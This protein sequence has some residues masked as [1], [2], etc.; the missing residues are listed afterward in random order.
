MILETE[1]NDFI[2]TYTNWLSE[3]INFHILKSGIAEITV[4]F[5]DRNNDFIT[6]YLLKQDNGQY[7]LSDGGVT[8]SELE[9]IGM[10]F[11]KHRSKILTEILNGYGVSI[12]DHKELYIKTNKQRL[13]QNKNMLLQAIH[14]VNDMVMLNKQTVLSLFSED[15]YTF[16]V[17]ND[18]PVVRDAK[19]SGKSG[20]DHKFDFTIAATRNNNEKLIN[21]SNRLDLNTSK[22]YLLA[23]LEIKQKRTFDFVVIY[24][25]EDYPASSQAI[26]ALREYETHIIPW[27]KRNNSIPYLLGKAS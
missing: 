10:N 19:F 7:V 3:Q 18:I 14:S 5:L 27:S 22:I 15:V 1:I 8:I 2:K 6:I 21:V 12:N 23:D 20:F 24:N 11:T 25:D 9:I 17:E 16:F 26:D 13:P 4:P